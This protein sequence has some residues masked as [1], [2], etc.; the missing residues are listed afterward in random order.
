M[1]I[2]VWGRMQ[3]ISEQ[4]V[5]CTCYN[6]PEEPSCYDLQFRVADKFFELLFRR[7]NVFRKIGQ[8]DKYVIDCLGLLSCL[9]TYAGSVVHGYKGKERRQGEKR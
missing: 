2:S 5:G 1:I 3:C 7:F 9:E 4:E 8:K 6:E